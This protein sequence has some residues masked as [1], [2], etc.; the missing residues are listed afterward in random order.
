MAKKLK[1]ILKR[2]R[3]L[4]YLP[5]PDRSPADPPLEAPMDLIKA[6]V[7]A[8]DAKDADAIGRLFVEDADF[9]NAVGLRWTGR[10][11]IVKGLRFGFTHMF[12]DAEVQVLELSQRLL[13]DDAAVVVAKWQITGQVDPDGQPVDA[14]RGVLSA[15]LIK[16]ADG[17]WLGVGCQNTDIAMA[18][19]T[20]VARAGT[21]TATSYIKGP[22]EAEIAAAELV[23]GD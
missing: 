5:F 6:F 20:N 8:W 3:E 12:P 9:V 10:R 2:A 17:S 22:S 7:K 14:R 16:L 21:L 13:G 19:D 23:E 15:T 4:S 1:K 18:A 11:S